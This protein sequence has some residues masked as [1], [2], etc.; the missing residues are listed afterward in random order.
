[1]DKTRIHALFGLVYLVTT[2]NISIELGLPL[3]HGIIIRATH[4]E[5]EFL[6]RRV[7]G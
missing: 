6:F 5:L 2:A 4:I 7:Q 1:M 3:Q